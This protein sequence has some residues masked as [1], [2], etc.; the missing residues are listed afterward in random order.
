M[1]PRTLTSRCNVHVK[2]SNVIC[3]QLQIHTYYL[4]SKSTFRM[5]LLRNF[6]HFVCLTETGLGQIYNPCVEIVACFGE[7]TLHLHSLG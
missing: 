6:V 7:M 3:S 2:Y 4:A 5:F 1:G